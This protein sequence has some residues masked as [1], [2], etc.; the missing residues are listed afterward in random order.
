MFDMRATSR[1]LASA[2]RYL[3]AGTPTGLTGLKTHASPR[4]ALLYTYSSTLEKL[5]QF[6]ETSVYR[7]A[8]EALTKHRLNIIEGVKP[9]GLDAWLQRVKETVDTH[10]EAFRRVGTLADSKMANVVYKNHAVLGLHT[11]EYDDEPPMKAEPEGPR[12]LEERAHQREAFSRDIKLE[13]AK[14]PRIEPE[15]P[16]SG[17]Q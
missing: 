8:T 7:Q 14:V 5:K 13:N 1:L 15:P 2:V 12:F 4:S 3:E 17:E 10:P 9:E 16:L 6:P 11:D